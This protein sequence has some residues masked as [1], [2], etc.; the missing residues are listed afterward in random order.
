MK[1]ILKEDIKGF[2]KAGDIKDVKPGYARNYLI[3][4]SLA[5]LAT[6]KNLKLL[7]LEKQRIEKEKDQEK[8]RIEELANIL[9]K[10][11]ININVKVGETGKL[12]GTITKE[13][14][15]ETIKSEMGIE[16]AKQDVLLEEPI[17]E[18]GVYSIEVNVKSEKFT[19]I[20][21]N[22]KVKVWVIEETQ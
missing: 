18:T 16:I 21:Q 6:E 14:I 7:E 13:D 5:V 15:A 19:E 22:A 1:I 3:P 17:K 8:K 2:G 20:Y 9:S 10:K 4:K 11:S 12:F